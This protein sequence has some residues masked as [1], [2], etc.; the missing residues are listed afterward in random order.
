M[1]S[2]TTTSP[3]VFELPTSS[4]K[5]FS[6]QENTEFVYQ[7]CK[8][9]LYQTLQGFNAS[10]FL[11]GQTTSGKTYTMLG[12][13]ANPGI[14]PFVLLDIFK[15]SPKPKA[16]SYIEIYNEQVSVNFSSDQ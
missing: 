7:S 10:L 15:E 8:P 12:D 6:A 2:I 11:Y 13:Q 1:P 16:I 9:L 5:V 14:L 4:D 3:S